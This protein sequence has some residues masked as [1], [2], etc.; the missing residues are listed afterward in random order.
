M[1]D[2]K[3]DGKMIHWCIEVVSKDKL[4]ERGRQMVHWLIKVAA[5]SDVGEQGREVV[6]RLV[7][8]FH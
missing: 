4:N 2:S 6:D 1:E 8:G 7:E 3:G 5:E